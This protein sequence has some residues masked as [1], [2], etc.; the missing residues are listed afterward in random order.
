MLKLESFVE[1]K[2]SE[3]AHCT[4]SPFF[5]PSIPLLLSRV[6]GLGQLLCPRELG[7]LLGVRMERKSTGTG[8]ADMETQMLAGP[9][10]RA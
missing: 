4:Y 3:P 9:L 10:A 7:G 2:L 1:T 6:L 5:P 8:P